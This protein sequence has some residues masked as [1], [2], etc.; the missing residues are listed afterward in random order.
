VVGPV[1]P[2]QSTRITSSFSDDHPLGVDIGASTQGVAGDPVVAS[3]G[4]VVTTAGVPNWSPSGSSYVIIDGTDS[5]T[6]RYTHMSDISISAGDSVT[7]GQHIGNMSDVGA[8]GQ[9][10]LHYE[11]FEN[12]QRIDPLTLYPNTTF[13]QPGD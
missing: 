1:F 7:G 11:V 9:V 10:H 3:F 6:Y 12:G 4:G 2:T 8:S 5:R 13:T